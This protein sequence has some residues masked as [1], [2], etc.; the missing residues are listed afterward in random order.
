[1]SSL[2]FLENI[3]LFRNILDRLMFV[4]EQRYLCGKP[5][6]L[7]VNGLMGPVQL[8]MCLDLLS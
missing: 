7:C 6:W 2:S 5:L 1:M 8:E 3:C 4:Q